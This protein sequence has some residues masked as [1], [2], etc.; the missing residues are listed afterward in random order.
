MMQAETGVKE[1]TDERGG[2]E[3]FD[4]VAD[5]PMNNRVEMDQVVTS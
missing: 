1:G 5:D 4:G 2:V 3:R